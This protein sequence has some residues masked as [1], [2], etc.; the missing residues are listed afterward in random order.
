VGP[1]LARSGPVPVGGDWAFEVKFDGM[2]LQARCEGRAVC[3]R[4]R[5]GRDCS[6]EFPE[7]AP[8]RTALGRHRV[9]LDGELVCLG[10][11]GTPDF[12]GLRGR[13]RAS[14]DGARRNAERRPVTF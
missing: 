9:L 14:A 7:L 4:S 12:A 6:E 8:I 5:P 13:L 1:M 11:D 10:A 2:R 3:L